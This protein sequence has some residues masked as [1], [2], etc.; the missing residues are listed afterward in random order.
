MHS[1][2]NLL[3]NCLTPDII[4]KRSQEKMKKIAVEK[5]EDGM[6]LARKVSNSSGNTLVS[7]GVSLTS[8]L[9]R[10]LKNWGI[11][12]V[13][14]EG[15]EQSAEESNT[16]ASSPEELKTHLLSKFSSV[17][18]NPIMERLFVAVYQYRLQKN[19]R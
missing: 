12:Y 6:V 19:S 10:R 2:T 3:H 16:I 18:E 13:Y 1:D 14:I 17:M 7:K 5:I 9:G 11:H 15:E 8:A 4:I